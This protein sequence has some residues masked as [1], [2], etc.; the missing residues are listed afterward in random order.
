[1]IT[2]VHFRWYTTNLNVNNRKST[3]IAE[4]VHKKKKK[5]KRTFIA[6]VILIRMQ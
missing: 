1:M 6:C 5:K 2:V 3:S 4:T